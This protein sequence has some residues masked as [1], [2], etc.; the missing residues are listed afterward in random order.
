MHKLLFETL[1]FITIDHWLLDLRDDGCTLQDLNV[2][3]D[4]DTGN[5]V[6]KSQDLFP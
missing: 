4:D 6:G 3:I 1:M 5:L 2:C